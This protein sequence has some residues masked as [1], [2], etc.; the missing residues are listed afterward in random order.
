MI[1]RKQKA[2]WVTSSGT[3]FETRADAVEAETREVLIK[4]LGEMEAYGVIEASPTDIA[5][6]LLRSPLLHIMSI[7][8]AK[9]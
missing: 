2:V 6:Q 4:V 9:K 3:E 8:G 5:Q 1:Q 7:S